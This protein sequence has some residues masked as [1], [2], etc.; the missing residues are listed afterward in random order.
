MSVI[1]FPTKFYNRLGIQS[2]SVRAPFS[3]KTHSVERAL[4]D[5]A[6]PVPVAQQPKDIHAESLAAHAED[7]LAM[8]SSHEASPVDSSVAEQATSVHNEQKA[9]IVVLGKGLDAIWENEDELAWRLWQNIMFALGWQDKNVIF[10]DLDC[11]VS[12]DALFHTME[13]I[14]DLSVD[15]VM[16]M[17]PEHELSEQLSE[18]VQV[19]EVPD[20][21]SMLSDAYAKQHFYSSV[22][23]FA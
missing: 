15:W 22:L 13:E 12:E 16:T 7:S 18:G 3:T 11:L 5:T 19:V 9:S 10:Y 1:K 23:K 4:S 6:S 8:T 21:E 14:I 20:L 17:E 2:W